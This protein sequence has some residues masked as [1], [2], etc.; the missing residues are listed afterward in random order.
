MSI[1]WFEIIVEMFNFLVLIWLLTKFFYKPVLQVMKDRQEQI[2]QVQL[3]ARG[4][5]EEAN[6]LIKSYLEKKTSLEERKE[7]ILDQAKEDAQDRKESLLADYQEEANFQRRAYLEEVVEERETFLANL[8]QTLGKNTVILAEHIFRKVAGQDLQKILF[9]DFL[10]KLGTIEGW[11]L[12]DEPGES[13]SL[14]SAF[15]LTEADKQTF[16]SA[17]A[18]KLNQVVAVDYVVQDDFILGYELQL[19][20][21]TLSNHLRK[22]LDESEKNLRQVLEE[23]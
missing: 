13:V 1:S 12:Q 4:K 9:K 3:E 5:M 18:N 6:D 17:L 14:S 16:E 2:N 21:L 7:A 22:Y 8:R 15:P 11:D 20:K 10:H 19:K 23:V